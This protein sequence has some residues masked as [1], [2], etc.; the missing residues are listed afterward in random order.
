MLMSKIVSIG[1]TSWDTIIQL[2]KMP[3]SISGN[4]FSKCSYTGLG[5]SAAG[6]ALTL[7][8]LGVDIQL[9]T[10]IGDDE[11][12]HKIRRALNEASLSYVEEIDPKGSVTH[13]N[14]MDDEGNRISIFTSYG[15][16][17]LP[18]PANCYEDLFKDTDYVLIGL[19]GFVK[20]FFHIIDATETNVWCDIHGYDGIDPYFQPFIDAAQVIFMSSEMLTDGTHA[21]LMKLFIEKG[22][23]FVVCTHGSDGAELLTEDGLWI[24][25]AALTS[26]DL[27]DANG[28]GDAFCSGFLYAYIKKHDYRTC[29]RYGH[30][31]AALTINTK[32]LYPEILN[33]LLIESL[34]QQHY[35]DK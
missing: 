24:K 35:G 28:A 3:D 13:T 20:D 15:S 4:I 29:L 5:A 23:K 11:A 18:Y 6:K 10:R 21:P 19:S 17:D 34:F 14:L 9:I 22:K 26:Y 30:I 7:N 2:N 31:A 12:G 33:V 8:Q 27:V 1:A 16:D 25:E 32:K